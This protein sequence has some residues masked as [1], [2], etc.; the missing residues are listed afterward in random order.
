[1]QHKG[2]NIP[3]KIIRGNNYYLKI[4]F[5]RTPNVGRKPKRFVLLIL[6]MSEDKNALI[7][8]NRVTDF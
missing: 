5:C 2:Y 1:M 3:A 6:N 8:H 4:Y 7:I